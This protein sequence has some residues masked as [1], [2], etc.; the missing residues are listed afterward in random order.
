MNPLRER[1]PRQSLAQKLSETLRARIESGELVEGDKLPTEQQLSLEHG[2]SRTVVRE[3]IATL[4][5]DRLIEAKQGSGAYVLGR[6]SPTAQQIWSTQS[7]TISSVI[8]TLELRA[9]MEIE[10]AGLAAARCS[11]AQEA[12]IQE[13]FHD[14]GTSLEDH[15]AAQDAD[16]RFHMAIAEATNN[17][18]FVE[19]LEYLGRR[20]IPRAQLHLLNPD[21]DAALTMERNLLAEHEAILR[22]ICAH[23]VEAARDAMRVHLKGS[24]ERYRQLSLLTNQ[25]NN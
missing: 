14:L 24:L 2:V 21:P 15:Q 4:K 17:R 3:A 25:T 12:R 22:A 6:S 23:D 13:R 19:F 8:E 18:Q 1:Q 9:A 10:A 7:Q 11:P 20:T 5:A 16:Y